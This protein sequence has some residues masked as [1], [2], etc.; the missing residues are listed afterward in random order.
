MGHSL[1]DSMKEGIAN[2][3]VVLVFLSTGYLESDNCLFELKEATEQKKKIITVFVESKEILGCLLTNEIQSCC[4]LDT[5][6]YLDFIQ[7]YD[8]FVGFLNPSDLSSPSDTRSMDSCYDNFAKGRELHSFDI[9]S[10]F[11]RLWSS[12]Y[13]VKA[14]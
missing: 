11:E 2:S 7:L 4:S 8:D 9:A 13:S 3:S 6:F 10:N 14:N 1:Q 5:C 12:T